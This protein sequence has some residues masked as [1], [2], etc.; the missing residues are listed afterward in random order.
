MEIKLNMENL[1]EQERD[2]LL[3]LVEKANKQ[4][5]WKPNAADYYYTVSFS[6]DVVQ[7]VWC[8]SLAERSAYAIG[9]CFQ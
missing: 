5:V 4:K 3:G 1:T 6:G 7:C 2:T 8:N 9:N